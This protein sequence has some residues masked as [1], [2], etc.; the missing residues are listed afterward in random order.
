MCALRVLHGDIG[1]I[2][3]YALLL[4]LFLFRIHLL[5]LLVLLIFFI[6]IINNYI[7]CPTKQK[8]KRK[9]SLNSLTWK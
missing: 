9:N 8:E 4:L 3:M 6:I 5:L 7:L 2:E 1:R